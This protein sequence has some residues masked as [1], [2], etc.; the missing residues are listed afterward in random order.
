MSE[1]RILVL[2]GTGVM[3]SYLVPALL[4]MG[5]CVDP[6]SL[7]NRISDH[8]KLRCIQ[9]DCMNILQLRRLLQTHYDAIVDFMVYQTFQFAERFELLLDSTQHYIFLSSYRVYSDRELPTRESSPRLLD[10][11]EDMEF[12]QTDDYSLYKAREENILRSSRYGNWSIIRPSIIYSNQRF[13]LTTLEAP[14]ILRMA[15]EGKRVFIPEEA[16]NVQATM[17]WA[18]DVAR[19]VA[20]LVCN[21]RAL[22]EAYTIATAEHH[23]WEEVASYYRDLIGLKVEWVDKQTYL[24]F[25]GN[26]L[27]AKFQLNY[28]RCMQRI[29]DNSKVLKHT[30]LQQESFM[31]LKDGLALELSRVSPDK[32]WGD[33]IVYNAMCRFMSL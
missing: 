20:R 28:D 7:D 15:R 24:G 29:M 4:E 2:G 10:I 14:Q 19:M 25:F 12:L 33:S 5:Y 31:P 32:E 23:S 21:P 22:G 6:V 26:T 13:Q 11:V 16:R 9:D 17:T 30:G 8:P 1:R 18:G 27:T 3:G